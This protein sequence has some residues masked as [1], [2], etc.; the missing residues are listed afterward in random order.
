M[1]VSVNDPRVHRIG[2]RQFV[3]VKAKMTEKAESAREARLRHEFIKVVPSAGRLAASELV[4]IRVHTQ[5]GVELDFSLLEQPGSVPLPLEGISDAHPTHGDLFQRDVDLVTSECNTLEHRLTLASSPLLSAA[6]IRGD[7]PID[8]VD[9][10][11]RRLFRRRASKVILPSESGDREI[12]LPPQP[13]HM[14]EAQIVEITAVIADL[15]PN[16]A[17]LDGAY[18]VADAQGSL[19]DPHEGVLAL[20]ARLKAKRKAG[21]PAEALL[22][23]VSCMDT[24]ARARLRVKLSFAWA[25]GRVSVVEILSVSPQ[26]PRARRPRKRPAP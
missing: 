9:V 22:T 14:P 2:Y 3:A 23:M 25:T 17:T 19:W 18:L 15:P 13:R 20:P 11:L 6:Q 12:K 26:E 1:E 21:Q 16:H 24:F 4:T 7:E 5:R 8:G 10:T